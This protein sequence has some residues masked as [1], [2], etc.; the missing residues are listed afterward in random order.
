MRILS[1]AAEPRGAD[2]NR[3][4]HFPSRG[5]RCTSPRTGDR[6]AGQGLKP[7]PQLKLITGFIARPFWRPEGAS[8]QK[9]GGRQE[10]HDRRPKTKGRRGIELT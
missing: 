3:C 10:K 7:P 6:A 1:G 9:N 8:N 4:P 2:G 5:P